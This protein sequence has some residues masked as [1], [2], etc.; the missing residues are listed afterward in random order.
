MNE[1]LEREEYITI[2]KWVIKEVIH[3]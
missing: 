3:F 1:D 2:L